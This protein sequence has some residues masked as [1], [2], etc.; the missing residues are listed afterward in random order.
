MPKV[1]LISGYAGSG[2]DTF[3]NFCLN[4]FHA[5]DINNVK[6][7]A[8]A[9]PIKDIA[10]KYFG[11]DGKKDKKGRQLLIDIGQAGRKYNPDIWVDKTIKEIEN[12]NPEIAIISDWRFKNEFEKMVKKFG[13]ENVITIRVKRDGIKAVNDISE[14]DLDDFHKFDLMVE[15]NGTLNDLEI[16]ASLVAI[17]IMYKHGI[18][19]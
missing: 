1:I 14:H 17:Y 15:N 5:T 12:D 13:R 16:Q 9:K 7:Y 6:K 3:V 10:I 19:V 4:T 8:F 11:W 18:R 2:K